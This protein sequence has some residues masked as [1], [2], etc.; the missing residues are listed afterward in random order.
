[1]TTIVTSVTASP[2]RGVLQSGDTVTFTLAMSSAVTVS[3]GT[4]TLTLS[5]GG[6]ALYDAAATAALGDPSKLVFTYK[7]AAADQPVDG[8]SFV[9][10]NYN[11]AAV[12]DATGQVPDFSGVYASS[13][14]PL[15]VDTAGPGT[16]VNTTLFAGTDAS[17]HVN[18]WVTNGTPAGTSELSV[19]G[20]SSNGLQPTGFVSLGNK[21]LFSGLD[22]T[23]H[24]A[25]WVSDG[26]AS[27]TTKLSIA[28]AS[29]NGFNPTN[30]TQVGDKVFFS[31]IDAFGHGNIWITDGTASGTSELFVPG[32]TSIAASGFTALGGKVLFSSGND[33]WITDG[34]T[35]GTSKLSVAG[36]SSPNGL[37]PSN[38]LA[39]GGK[40]L[41]EGADSTN[42]FGLWVTD[43][44][45]A[46]TSELSVAG[47]NYPHSFASIGDKVMFVAQDPTNFTN[48]LWVTDGTS[49]GTS[50]LQIPGTYT[51]GGLTAFGGKVI[52]QYGTDLWVSDGTTAGT[53]KLDVS[54][55]SG[56]GIFSSSSFE[57]TRSQFGGAY[58]TVVGNEVLFQG[59]DA[60][61]QVALW[62]TDG[63]AAGTFEIPVSG[64]PQAYVAGRDFATI[65]NK[66][67]FVGPGSAADAL[68]VSDGTSAGTYELGVPARFSLYGDAYVV[69]H[70]YF[71]AFGSKALFAV[72]GGALW[73]S[74]GTTAGTYQLG[75]AS[76][77]YNR[78]NNNGATYP[79]FTVFGDHAL[80]AGL[81]AHGTGLWVTDGTSAGT[82]ELSVAGAQ[83]LPSP[84]SFGPFGLQ[85]AAMQVFGTQVLFGGDDTTGGYGLWITDGTSAG[86]TELVGGV[87]A[88]GHGAAWNVTVLGNKAVFDT[89]DSTGKTILGVTDGTAAGT[90]VLPVAGASATAFNPSALAV[91][92]NKVVFTGVDA[93]GKNAIWSTDGTSVGTSEL[94]AGF[95]SAPTLFAQFRGKAI[96]KA[97]DAQPELWVSDG[98]VAGT[99][100]FYIP[101]GGAN[102][103]SLAVQSDRVVFAGTDT[104][105]RYSLW[106]SDGTLAGTSELSVAGAYVGGSGGGIFTQMTPTAVTL[107]GKT[108]FTGRDASTN[109]NLFVTDGTSAGSHEIVVNGAA[110]TGLNP[111]NLSVVNGKIMFDG[112]DASGKTSLWVSD[113]TSAGTVELSS[114]PG[115]LVPG[116][117]GVVNPPP[118]ASVVSFT[119]SP[120]NG[121]VHA[122]DTVTFTMTMSRGVTVSGGTPTLT[123][124]DGGTAVYDAA[125]TAALGDPTKM[126]FSYTVGASDLSESGLSFVRG[127]QNG[128][129][130]VDSSGNVP[131]FSGAFATSFS[132]IQV[133]TAPTAVT[134]IVASPSNGVEKPG[135][136]VTFTITM[137]RAVTISGGTP[138]LTLNDGGIASYDAAATAALGDPAKMVFSYTVGASDAEVNG[139]SFVRGDQ[140]GSVIVDGQGKGPDFSGI[141]SASFSGLQIAP[142]TVTSVVASPSSA[143]EHAGDTVT[144]TVTLNRGVSV[145]GGAPV[146]TLNDGGVAIYDAAATAALGDPTKL[147][148]SYTV[149]AT[150]KSVNGLSFAKGDLNGTSIIDAAGKSPDLSGLFSSGFSGIQIATA[151]GVQAV[152]TKFQIDNANQNGNAVTIIAELGNGTIAAAW[153]QNGA[154]H[155]QIFDQNG[156]KLGAESTVSLPNGSIFPGSITALTNGG[157]AVAWTTLNNSE[158]LTQLYNASGAPINA[159][160]QVNTTGAVEIDNGT[161]TA[162]ANGGFVAAWNVYDGQTTT[163]KAQIYD[164]NGARVGNEFSPSAQ[165]NAD[166]PVITGLADGDFIVISHD[167]GSFVVTGQIFDA[168]GNAVGAAFAV[169]SGTQQI[170]ETLNNLSVAALPT[171][172]FVVSWERD[173]DYRASG[174]S[175][176]EAQQFDAAGGKIASQLAVNTFTS[177]RSIYGTNY[178]TPEVAA[179]ADG[180]FVV[181]WQDVTLSSVGST[182][183]I[184]AQVFDAYNQQKIGTEFGLDT[185]NTAGSRSQ[186]VALQDGGFAIAWGDG[187]GE[188]GQVYAANPAVTTIAAGTTLE[189]PGAST[190]KLAFAPGGVAL[191]LDHSAAFAG[192]ITG[193]GGGDAIDLADI[194]FNGAAT[195]L[196]YFGSDSN[197]GGHLAVSDG[198]HAAALTLLG[199]YSVASFVLSADGHGGTLITAAA[200]AA[201]QPQLAA[202]A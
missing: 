94:F 185:V 62:R 43:G 109:I 24:K 132:G 57:S 139:L 95:G 123:L 171:G 78:Y 35:A 23:N 164:G 105:G 181:T 69:D 11:G 41:F 12:V 89:F 51:V 156:G 182:S 77:F 153:L 75:N 87:S 31:A 42:K 73:V 168:Q 195:T 54:N 22:A 172:G 29:P 117:F 86:T 50:Q 58:F 27:G 4:P 15:Q 154:V 7:V 120:A 81:G 48:T 52:F 70:P 188:K 83:T 107:G 142:T 26:T 82:Y 91:A 196:G 131:D 137:N 61:D 36:A 1:M 116:P 110:A 45:A 33:L 122:G 183:S 119:G 66:S 178:Y 190:A 114:Q 146:L 199:Q 67:F 161:I 159:T 20:A 13:F 53:T 175:A 163:T 38:L 200:D 180:N 39:F 40:V 136:T 189:I 149:G 101:G 102:M 194:A 147:V 71:A 19:A 32:L 46:G 193:F 191:Q 169:H 118:P 165:T 184:K 30:L 201:H 170:G 155:T 162:L 128:A 2:A 145:S 9:R 25:L 44:T 100:E 124:N 96:F 76:P 108:Y 125:A 103:Y 112:V 202:H 133:A 127:D 144:F 113:G 177:P 84:T 90:T 85:P 198:N 129:V 28:G 186:V 60:N 176:I 97:A 140:N 17:G 3:G 104:S 47:L 143:T 173:Y 56:F 150:D 34:T 179:L 121:V 88:F 18:L 106:S 6:A 166:R 192:S 80:F 92:G 16:P 126:V 157:F 141:F 63:T 49:A 148:F 99:T 55:A 158:V 167:A 37:Q 98:T 130:I 134:S 111:T 64:V 115:S 174:F 72:D 138:T 59:R 65:G 197:S 79:G 187:S 8:L 21:V 160:F 151:P 10:G 68:W 135:D 93:A 74:D 14:T 152:G 5:D